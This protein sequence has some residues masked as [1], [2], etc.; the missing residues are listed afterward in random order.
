MDVPGCQTEGHAQACLGLDGEILPILFGSCRVS[1]HQ[2]GQAWDVGGLNS[3]V[4]DGRVGVMRV[5]LPFAPTPRGALHIEHAQHPT[6]HVFV[7]DLRPMLCIS[8][9]LD[10]FFL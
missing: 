2:G 8:S 5:K 3:C 9:P 4:Q 6:V 1:G 10:P 7:P